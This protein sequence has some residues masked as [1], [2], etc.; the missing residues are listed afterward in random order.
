MGRETTVY[1]L[2]RTFWRGSLASGIKNGGD[3]GMNILELWVILRIFSMGAGRVAC[4][5]FPVYSTF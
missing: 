4:K 2:T 5:A 1:D 3:I